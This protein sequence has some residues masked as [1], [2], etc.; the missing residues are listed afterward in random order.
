MMKKRLTAT[1]GSQRRLIVACTIILLFSI[2]AIT[3]GLG[4][5][6]RHGCWLPRR[7]SRSFANKQQQRH[8][9]WLSSESSSSSSSFEQDDPVKR[10]ME[11]VRSIQNSFYQ[12]NNDTKVSLDP[13]TGIL[14]NLPLWRVQW[15]ELPGRSNVLNVHEGIYTNMFESIISNGKPCYVGHL[16]LP[17]GSNNIKS[18][19]DCFRL[20]TWQEEIISRQEQGA[21][22]SSEPRSSVVGTLL[23]VT[24]YRRLTDGRIVLLVQ[25]LERFVVTN[26]QRQLPY[27]IADVQLL[28]DTD[29]SDH[30][31]IQVLLEGEARKIR[32]KAVDTSL[33]YHLYEHA[34]MRLPLPET[35]TGL[36]VYD[37]FT[38]NLA[39]V[40]PFS[41]FSK[42]FKVL[43]KAPVL[44]VDTAA[45]QEEL[46]TLK[47]QGSFEDAKEKEAPALEARLLEGGILNG[48][49]THPEVSSS[50]SS[51]SSL[52]D[53]EYHLWLAV[54]NFLLATEMPISPHMLA[55][56]QKRDAWPTDFVLKKTLEAYLANNKGPDD[57]KV[58][59]VSHGYVSLPRDYPDL[60][61]QRRISFT[62]AHLLEG[63]YGEESMGL[64]QLLLEIPSTRMRLLFLLE[65]FEM[66]YDD[67]A[68]TFQ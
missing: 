27:S 52:Y 14:R 55:L 44:V 2:Q 22:A 31:G 59:S 32:A 5:S 11:M 25:A 10:K 64:R 20:K 29:E 68:G 43:D 4:L 1:F 18:T 60:R 67:V 47:E 66:I 45:A 48:P 42:R 49:P 15:T 51:D 12:Q 58:V 50:M 56:L 6:S 57:G 37:A 65:R 9:L 17:D 39:T 26:V 24:D 38:S 13:S 40:L 28:P 16:Y 8:V 41:A 3:P 36:S 46:T 23:N 63:Y 19:N 33:R 35:K 62:L 54:N 53:I 7:Y 61:R 34:D 21:A 30:D